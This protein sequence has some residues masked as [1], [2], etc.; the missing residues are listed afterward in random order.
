MGR[1]KR[2]TN[3]WLFQENLPFYIVGFIT[4]GIGLFTIKYGAD[5]S[6]LGLGLLGVFVMVLGI[7]MISNAKV[8]TKNFN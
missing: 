8:F 2:V 4:T 3:K 1:K 5:N 6:I 7:M